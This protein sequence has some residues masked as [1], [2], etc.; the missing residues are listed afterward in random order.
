MFFRKRDKAFIAWISTIMKSTSMDEDEYVYKEGEQ[1][2]EGKL[3]S[4]FL[5]GSLNHKGV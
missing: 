4:F 2:N 1:M 5:G 3:L